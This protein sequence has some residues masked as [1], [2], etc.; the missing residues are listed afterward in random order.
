M[1]FICPISEVT[2]FFGLCRLTLVSFV[3]IIYGNLMSENSQEIVCTFINSASVDNLTIYVLDFVLHPA[4]DSIY[5]FLKLIKVHPPPPQLFQF[6]LYFLVASSFPLI[7]SVIYERAPHISASFRGITN[8]KV[9][10]NFPN[11]SSSS[12]SSFLS[13]PCCC[14]NMP[15]LLIFPLGGILPALISPPPFLSCCCHHV[16]CFL[17]QICS[18][19]FP[20][21]PLLP[22]PQ[23]FQ[24]D[25]VYLGRPIAPSYMSPNAGRGGVCGVSANEYC[26]AHGDQINFGDLTP[27]LINLWLHPFAVNHSPFCTM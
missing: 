10:F 21:S 25:V 18:C 15:E 5:E 14:P 20:L 9:T 4:E 12:F 3:N 19:V 17:R 24:R 27:Y 13:S 22:P 8:I 26:C 6:F 16:S 1:V 2:G 7:W 23:S 11:S